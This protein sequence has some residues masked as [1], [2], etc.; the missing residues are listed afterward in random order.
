MG[1]T[2]HRV[3]DELDSQLASAHRQQVGKLP[4]TVI[5]KSNIRSFVNSISIKFMLSV[6][7]KFKLLL[8]INVTTFKI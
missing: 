3:H 2:S 6:Q 4:L 8:Y 7:D 1:R 5:G